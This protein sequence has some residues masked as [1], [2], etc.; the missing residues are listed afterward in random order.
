MFNVC[1]NV[2]FRLFMGGNTTAIMSLQNFFYVFDSHRRDERGLNIPNGRLVLL[3]FRYIFE[4][5][6]YIQ[7]SYLEFSKQQMYFQVQFIR[8]RQSKSY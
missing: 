5:E 8:L 3:K 4:I 1:D 2:L 6:K 7:A